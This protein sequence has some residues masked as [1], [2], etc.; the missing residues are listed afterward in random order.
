[1]AVAEKHKHKMNKLSKEQYRLVDAHGTFT[2]YYDEFTFKSCGCG[3]RQPIKVERKSGKINAP[4]EDN[5][6]E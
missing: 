1:M 4:T 3:F 5:S 2:P 6:G